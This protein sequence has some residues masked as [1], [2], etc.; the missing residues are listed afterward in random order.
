MVLVHAQRLSNILA[1]HPSSTGHILATG[2]V[3]SIFVYTILRIFCWLCPQK[4]FSYRELKPPYSCDKNC[5]GHGNA[6][7]FCFQVLGWKKKVSKVTHKP[8][9]SSKQLACLELPCCCWLLHKL[10]MQWLCIIQEPTRNGMSCCFPVLKP[11]N[12][13]KRNVCWINWSTFFGEGNQT[14]LWNQ[15]VPSGSTLWFHV[16]HIIQRRSH[17]CDLKL[18]M[19][20]L[21]VCCQHTNKKK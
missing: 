5:A 8:S 4:A 2:K 19:A 1:V 9:N 15:V 21:S 6:V 16:E 13:N 11:K 12:N 20:V 18:E 17:V 14:F 3:K 7:C 10:V